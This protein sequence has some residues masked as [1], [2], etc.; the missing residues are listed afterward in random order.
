M[1]GEL[2]NWNSGKAGIRRYQLVVR[3]GAS[4]WNEM[5]PEVQWRR[6]PAG[7]KDDDV[8]RNGSRKVNF[9]ERS[10]QVV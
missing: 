9:G 4:G 1:P 6:Q 2:G 10:F 7:L 5:E 8:E 3:P